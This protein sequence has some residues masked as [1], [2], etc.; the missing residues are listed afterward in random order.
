MMRKGEG[1]VLVR[2]MQLRV[3]P[4]VPIGLYCQRAVQNPMGTSGSTFQWLRFCGERAL[5][6]DGL[7]YGFTSMTP[8]MIGQ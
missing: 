1:M 5:R 6:L 4:D 2:S 8:F 3:E 7:V